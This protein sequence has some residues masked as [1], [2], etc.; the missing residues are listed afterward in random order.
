MKLTEQEIAQIEKEYE[1]LLCQAVIA[2]TDEE[3]DEIEEL[4]QSIEKALPLKEVL[5]RPFPIVI[6]NFIQA[7]YV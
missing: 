6:H 3:V 5:K 2:K 1:D 7:N 4:K